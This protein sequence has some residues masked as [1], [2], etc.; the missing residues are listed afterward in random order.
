MSVMHERLLDSF[1]MLLKN[2]LSPLYSRIQ[3]AVDET[4]G[5]RLFY[6]PNFEQEVRM[7]RVAVIFVPYWSTKFTLN[8]YLTGPAP[9]GLKIHW[10]Q[11]GE[12]IKN[13]S[14]LGFVE[15]II[16]DSVP[17]L[18]W[19]TQAIPQYCHTPVKHPGQGWA[20]GGGKGLH[21]EE[22]AQG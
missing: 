5:C 3:T 6:I 18:R 21:T 20:P 12:T 1:L 10:A 9:L 13:N 4:R 14:N 2:S 16:I 15:P 22:W 11:E 8:P 7:K 19:N 17:L